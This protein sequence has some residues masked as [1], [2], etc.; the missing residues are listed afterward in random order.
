MYAVR[1]FCTRHARTFE[2][3]YQGLEKIFLSLHPLLKKIGYNRLERPV[4]LVEQISKGLLFDCKMC[5]QCVLSSTG[6]SCPMNCP[7]NI[8]NGPCGGVRDGGFC[9]VSPQMR[10]VWVEAWDGAAQ[11]K[12]GLERIRVVQP[13]VNREL[14]G[15]SSWLRVIREKGAMK[16]ASRRQHDADKSELAQAFAGARKL[17]PAAVPLAREP[18]AALAEQ[19]VPEQTSVLASQETDTKGTGAK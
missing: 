3:I 4:A 1:L 9:E 10:C 17:E 12:N 5:G 2:T 13:P 16:E 18:E 8:R 19:A 15:S 11:M 7:K 14:K 6:M